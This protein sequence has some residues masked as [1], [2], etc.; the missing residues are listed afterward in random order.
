[1]TRRGPLYIVELEDDQSS[2]ELSI[3]SEEYEIFR[4][5]LKID[6]Y[7]QILIKVREDEYTGGTKLLVQEVLDSITVRENNLRSIRILL[8]SSYLTAERYQETIR[9]LEECL[10]RES[11]IPV[12]IGLALSEARCELSLGKNWVLQPSDNI[13]D[14]VRGYFGDDCVIFNL[15]GE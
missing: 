14:K 13:L 11:G 1:M 7:L 6:E 2:A 4:Q 9:K 10:S 3:Y 5:K 8:A 12:L 15:K